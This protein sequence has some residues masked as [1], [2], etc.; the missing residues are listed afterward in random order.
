MSLEITLNQF[1]GQ[2]WTLSNAISK[3]LCSTVIPPSVSE[4]PTLLQCSQSLSV[5]GIGKC[6][7]LLGVCSLVRA[8]CGG[9]KQ[10]I[11]AGFC[12]VL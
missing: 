2:C 12:P 7:S 10:L 8:A 4:F 3:A 1:Q 11:L 6:H 9:V 5:E